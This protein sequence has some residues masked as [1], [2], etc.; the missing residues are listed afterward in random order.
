MRRILISILTL[1]VAIV[2]LRAVDS[3]AAGKARVDSLVGEAE[4]IWA[5][6]KR[7]RRVKGQAFFATRDFEL[8]AIPEAVSLSIAADEEY[9]LSLNGKT[10]GSGRQ[11]APMIL[12]SYRVEDLLEVGGNRIFVELRSSRGSGGCLVSLSS[13]DAG[14]IVHTDLSWRIFRRYDAG[15]ARGL[16]PLDRGEI[17]WSWGRPRV[18]RWGSLDRAEERQRWD[19][20]VQ[21][22]FALHGRI[23]GQTGKSRK[24]R[25]ELADSPIVTFDFGRKVT[26]F[27]SFE[28]SR[29]KELK[30]LL[31]TGDES[32]GDPLHEEPVGFV[33]TVPD[34]PTWQDSVVRSFRFVTLVGVDQRVRAMVLET[35]PAQIEDARWQSRTEVGVLGIDPPQLR[36][37]MKN[38]I[39]RELKGGQSSP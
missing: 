36:S 33:V 35:D 15:I 21:G 20:L 4:W 18:G 27:L 26:G 22:P 30:A 31:Y 16:L 37:P 23:F 32:P 5:G 12:D 2:C 25:L 11:R 19:Q 7:L 1:T 10:V 14:P 9:V 28:L 6:G 8:N 3:V 24:R 17:P 38:E 29:K 34:S 13:P 39:W